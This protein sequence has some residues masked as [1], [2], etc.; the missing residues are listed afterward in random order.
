VTS[1]PRPD[2]FVRSLAASILLAAGAG[3][4]TVGNG[5]LATL[6]E[7][8][9]DALLVPGTETEAQAHEALGQGTVIRFDSGYETW[10]YAWR[11][12]LAK[13]WDDVPFIG[14]VTSRS[15]R[16]EKEL[17]LLFDPSGTLRRWSFQETGA[18]QGAPSP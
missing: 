14:L 5:R 4:T 10:H 13:G 7:P 8:G 18:A 2:A 3:C 16:P 12:G 17:V 15:K 9:L 1:P 6:D 11:E